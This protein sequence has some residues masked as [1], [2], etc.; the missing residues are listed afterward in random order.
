[1]T[2][3]AT[4]SW[5]KIGAGIAEKTNDYY[6]GFPITAVPGPGSVANPSLVAIGKA[7]IGMSYPPFLVSA[8]NGEEPYDKPFTNLRTVAALTQTVVH[9]FADIDPQVKAVIDI[10]ENKIP[11]SIGIPSKGSG[12]HFISKIM[13]SALGYEDAEVVKEWGSKIYYGSGSSLLSA[14][15]DRHT[16]VTII[17]YNVP[18][19][20]IEECLVARKGI[21]LDTGEDLRKILVEEKGFSPYTIPSGTY[22]GQDVDVETVSLPIVIFTRDDVSEEVVYNLTKAIYKNKDYLIGVHS[23]FKVFEPE[24][25]PIGV[26][27]ELHKGAEKFYK[28]IGLIK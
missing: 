21:L 25:M 23:S 20:S 27:I 24:N 12:S 16:N 28:E 7:D 1:M 18:A 5:I 6:E 26:A 3:S 10:I 22:Y 4:G 9:V 13:F 17:T 19:S 14:W 8:W 11:I 15:K 2:G